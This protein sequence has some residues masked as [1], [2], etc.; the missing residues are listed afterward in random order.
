MAALELTLKPYLFAF[1]VMQYGILTPGLHVSCR[2]KLKWEELTMKSFI[3]RNKKVMASL[4]RFWPV[5]QIAP[6]YKVGSSVETF[7][8]INYLLSRGFEGIEEAKL[9]ETLICSEV[10]DVFNMLIERNFTP[11]VNFIKIFNKK[12][13][14]VQVKKM[15][16]EGILPSHPDLVRYHFLKSG[17]NQFRFGKTLELLLAYLAIEELKAFSASFGVKIKH[18]PDGGD[19]DCIAVFRDDLIYFEAKSG[20][21]NNISTSSIFSFLKRHVFLAPRASI[22]FIDFEGGENSLDQFVR[23]FLNAPIGHRVIETI[24]KVKDGTKKFYAVEGDILIVDIHSDGD[25][26][27]NLRLA[28]QYIH[29]YNS[30]QKNVMYNLIK[31]EYLGYSSSIL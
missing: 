8:I 1:F 12:E 14:R 11:S 15:V 9:E 28:M 30:F 2:L 29:R 10:S 21:V 16:Y 24:R 4:N 7:N 18:A 26:L 17:S 20:N 23:Q 6:A 31:P 5:L 3:L 27:S 22:L 25:I 13:I 19:F